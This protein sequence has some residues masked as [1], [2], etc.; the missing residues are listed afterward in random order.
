MGAAV[1]VVDD[2][3]EARGHGSVLSLLGLARSSKTYPY[4]SETSTSHFMFGPDW[5]TGAVGERG[6]ADIGRGAVAAEVQI[7]VPARGIGAAVGIAPNDEIVGA[8]AEREVDA[9]IAGIGRAVI[10]EQGSA[11]VC[12]RVGQPHRFCGYRPKV[13]RMLTGQADA[14]HR[15][16]N[17]G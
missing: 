6:G 13:S 5:T 14:R 7:Q 8:D 11:A 9:A 2:I 4:H 10:V 16:Y 1:D 15:K 12:A 17:P 3:A